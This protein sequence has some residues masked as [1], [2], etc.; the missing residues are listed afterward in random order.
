M[1]KEGESIIALVFQHLIALGIFIGICIT[2]GWNALVSL[3]WNFY[4][5]CR[6]EGTKNTGW[7]HINKK[8]KL[9][10]K[11]FTEFS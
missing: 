2:V 6:V 5:C 11:G 9:I 4:L 7:I 10:K 3:Y 8:Q 1:D